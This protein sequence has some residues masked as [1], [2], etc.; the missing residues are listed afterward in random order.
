MRFSDVDQFGHVNNIAQQ[1]YFDL[2]KTDFFSKLWQRTEALGQ[3]PAIIVSLKT[4]FYAQLHYGDELEVISKITSIGRKSFCL[5]Q[6]IM[7]TDEECS[8]SEVVM[9]CFDAKSK[10]AVEVPDQWREMLEIE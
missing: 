8:R 1:A 9:V 10:Q 3:V 2:G 5:R 7:R 4:D 6:S